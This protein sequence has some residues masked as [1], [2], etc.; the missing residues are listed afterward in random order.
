MV[1]LGIILCTLFWRSF[2][3]GYVNFSNDNPLG[4]LNSTW[5][6]FPKTLTGV[7]DDLNSIGIYCGSWALDPSGILLGIL[8]PVGYSK[9]LYPV[10]LLFLGF[11]AWTFFRQLRLSPLAATLGALAVA[12]NSTFFSDVC[13]GVAGHEIAYGMDF[14]ALALIVSNS[15]TTPWRVRWTRLVL[16]G[17]SV[18]INVIEGVDVGA[19]FSVL[20][21][22]FVLFHSIFLENGTVIKKMGRG[23]GRTIFIAICAALIAWQAI[24]AL[25]T[26][27]IT[28]IVGVADT[29]QDEQTRT[30]HWDFATQWSFPK[31]ETFGIL[32]P[33]LFGYRMDAPDGGN[34][35]GVIGR[36]AGT[37]RFSGDGYYAG[38]LIILV[39][40]WAIA[41]SFRS[42]N[43]IFSV[44]HRRSLW[45][46]TAVLMVA[47]LLSWGRF[48]PFYALFYKL[49]YFSTIRDPNKFLS[50]FS[51]ALVIIFAYGVHGLGR[52]YLEIPAGGSTSWLIQ[53]KVWW[54]KARGF[55]R[56]WTF[57]CVAAI[58]VGLL[59]WL[60]YAAQKP[61]LV[62]YLQT[63][64]FPDEDTAKQIASFSVW[65]GGW[66]IL[67][68]T[69]GIGFLTLVLA[70][71][72]SGRRA[73]WGGNWGGILLGV[74]LVADLG[75]A[76]RSW[77]VPWDYI[78]KYDVDPADHAN[79]TNPIINFLRDKSYEHRVVML[80]FNFP[81]Q[82]VLFEELYKIEWAQHHFPYYDIQSLDVIQ[83]PRKP[84]DLE[85][86]DAALAF[87]NIP[88]TVYLIARK[89]QLTN[90]RYLLGPAGF[91]DT[92]NE[93]LDPVQHRFRIVQ[94]FDVAPKPGIEQPTKL[95][96]L[97]A[98]PNANGNYAIF[99]FTGALPRAK[100]YSSWQISTNDDATLKT[101]AATNFDPA[102]IVLVATNLPVPPPASTT[103]GN[104]GTVDFKS[105]APKDIVFDT[106][107]DA[108]SV[109]LLND[110]FD[111]HWHVLVDGQ[112]APLLRCNFIMRGV[113]LTPGAHT[114]E[115]QFKTIRLFY[116]T[117]AAW[118]MGI[119][120]CGFLF[121]STRQK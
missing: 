56:S 27:S 100:L 31:A 52:Y 1:L 38:I 109:L 96:E 40:L 14:L 104:S 36:G 70:G 102:K 62:R 77:I 98:A 74:L 4:A 48:A 76:D 57:A 7:W 91:L 95:E 82:F 120:L 21:A 108:A 37:M 79:S 68:F 44:P 11:A 103:N 90:T 51:W 118:T 72:F 55:D 23:I 89:W 112:P 42:Q 24:V 78:Q 49:P 81:H 99:E 20:V 35:W 107:T 119:L 60:I 64:G 61:A 66:F 30:A 94:R 17:L 13:W 73:K 43:S 28:N 117:L 2:L 121:F 18:G 25:L 92:L 83:M 34:Y 97:T 101:L 85:D 54:T 15:P 71:V 67:F 105:Y 65:Q 29:Q 58:V 19:I 26:T 69:L 9:F 86:F 75:R 46:W 3:P 5:S 59:A 45:F 84:V 116:V 50:V 39:A 10:A 87:R 88:E 22:A 33:G 41:Q 110:K 8:G 111:T 53:L 16:A 12:L 47:L 6:Q 93:Q 106:K 63:V 114:V 115:F 80:P 32:V 113:Y